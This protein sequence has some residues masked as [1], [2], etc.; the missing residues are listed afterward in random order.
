MASGSRRAAQRAEAAARL[1]K[2]DGEPIRP[3]AGET[4]EDGWTVRRVA[5]TVGGRRYRCPGCDQE[6]DGSGP[7]VVAWPDGRS[8]DRRHWHTPCWDA[9]GRRGVKVHRSKNAP[10]FG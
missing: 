1:R 7:H 3:P 4:V 6:L 2:G 5:G 8:D 10:R 9:R